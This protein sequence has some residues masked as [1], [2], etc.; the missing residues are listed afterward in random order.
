MEF[1]DLPPFQEFKYSFPHNNQYYGTRAARGNT[2]GRG[3]QNQVGG[4]QELMFDVRWGS[5]A[6]WAAVGC[7]R[8]AQVANSPTAESLTD[9]SV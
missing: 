9:L 7:A 2:S 1:S 6:P 5:V 8:A 3:L 4:I